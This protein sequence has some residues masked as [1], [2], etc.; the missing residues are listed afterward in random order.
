VQFSSAGFDASNGLKRFVRT[1]IMRSKNKFHS[2]DRG[3]AQVE[4][5]LSV[6]SLIFVMFWLVQLMLFLYTYVVMAGAAKEG[7]RYAVVHGSRNGSPSGPA[8]NDPAV[9]AAV[10]NYANYGGMIVNV[11]YLD[12]NNDPSSRVRVTVEYPFIKILNVVWTPPT[13]R[14]AS[15]GRIV[16]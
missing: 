1:T 16:Y 9:V 11:R 13:I 5:L 6:L 2:K 4:F 12:G 3:Q 14:A 7:V 15:Q 8:D 10:T